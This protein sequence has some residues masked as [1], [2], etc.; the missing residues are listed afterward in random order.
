MQLPIEVWQSKGAIQAQHK[1]IK[2]GWLLSADI[3]WASGINYGGILYPRFHSHPGRVEG[4]RSGGKRWS[5]GRP[6]QRWVCTECRNRE[7]YWE[8]WEQGLWAFERRC[9]VRSFLL[10]LGHQGHLYQRHVSQPD[11]PLPKFRSCDQ[12]LAIRLVRFLSWTRHLKW[13]LNSALRFEQLY[14]VW[15]RERISAKGKKSLNEAEL[16]LTV[17]VFGN[18]GVPE[19]P[20]SHG[21]S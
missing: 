4:R 2:T 18:C 1:Y 6:T 21:W 3:N 8:L 20:C 5:Q 19:T 11:L 14:G 16:V 17:T 13:I 7:W 9:S 15:G 12:I 10:H